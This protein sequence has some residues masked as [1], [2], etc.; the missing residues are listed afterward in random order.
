MH[1]KYNIDLWCRTASCLFLRCFGTT[2]PFIPGIFVFC[3][4]AA[5][6]LQIFISD[7]IRGIFCCARLPFYFYS[8]KRVWTLVH[9]I[10]WDS[11]ICIVDCS[12]SSL[13]TSRQR[14]F[15]AHRLEKQLHLWCHFFA[16]KKARLKRKWGKTTKEINKN[17]AP[18]SIQ[19]GI[20]N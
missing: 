20:A 16:K 7:L 6:L 17:K 8:S 5:S 13:R 10:L 18:V 3:R 1:T 14:F 15:W 11:A 2:A 12:F 9:L 19:V 4:A